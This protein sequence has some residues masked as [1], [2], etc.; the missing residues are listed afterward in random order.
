MIA[1][2]PVAPSKDSSVT[3]RKIENGFIVSKMGKDYRQTEVFTPTNPMGAIK[4]APAKS[5]LLTGAKK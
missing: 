3:V 1:N 2:A 5:N 4:S